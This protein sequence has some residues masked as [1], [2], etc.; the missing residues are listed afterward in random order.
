M[1]TL[2]LERD[3]QKLPE[4]R[5]VFGKMPQEDNYLT[6]IADHQK[7]TTTSGV[8]RISTVNSRFDPICEVLGQHS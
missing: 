8:P 3:R 1:G 5:V 6:V 4:L 7:I 2:A